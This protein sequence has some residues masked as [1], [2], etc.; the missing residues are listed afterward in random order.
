MTDVALLEVT[1]LGKRF[2]G[3]IALQAIELA[4]RDGERVGL[5]G[6]ERLWQ[7]HAGELHVRHA[8]QRDGQRAIC[9]ACARRPVRA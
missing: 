1:N 5:I 9:R 2:G 6:P 4:V 3:F 8:A 7:E